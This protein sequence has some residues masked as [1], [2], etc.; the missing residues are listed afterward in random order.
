M[1]DSSYKG[2]KRFFVLACDNT[3][4][5][6]QVSVDYFKKCFL[7]RVKI[8]DYNIEIDGRKFYDQRMNGLIK[9]YDEVRKNVNTTG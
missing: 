3:A 1:L 4:G 9:Q 7:L 2:V 6:D 8:E 5:N